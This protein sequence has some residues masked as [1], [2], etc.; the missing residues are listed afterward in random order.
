M[1]LLQDRHL[2]TGIVE[3]A[4]LPIIYNIVHQQS[5]EIGIMLTSFPK[6]I[7]SYIDQLNALGTRDDFDLKTSFLSFPE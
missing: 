6:D 3:T 2:Y 5:Q 1:D 7:N 4:K